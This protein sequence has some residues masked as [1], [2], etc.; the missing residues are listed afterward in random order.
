[1]TSDYCDCPQD[2]ECANRRVD[3]DH[4]CRCCDRVKNGSYPHD[5]HPQCSFCYHRCPTCN[6][7]P[8]P[9][10]TWQDEG[11]SDEEFEEYRAKILE[12]SGG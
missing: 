3:G 5:L 7:W 8:N 4:F 12:N 6:T 11:V 1:M 9:K 2:M 10:C